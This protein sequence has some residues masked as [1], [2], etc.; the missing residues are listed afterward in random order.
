MEKP[1]TGHCESH[2]LQD[3]NAIT[4]G[5]I[6][7]VEGDQKLAYQKLHFVA[8]HS[9][10]DDVI[11]FA[12]ALKKMATEPSAAKHASSLTDLAELMSREATQSAADIEAKEAQRTTTTRRKNDP[13]S[14]EVLA[15]DTQAKGKSLPPPAPSASPA[16]AQIEGRT[17]VPATDEGNRACVLSGIMSPLAESS[18][19]YCVRAAK[20]PIVVT[21]L[22]SSSACPAELFAIAVVPGDLSSP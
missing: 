16:M 5:V 18:R 7:Y 9:D 12:G 11:A 14:V 22:H 6:T 20:G 8:S 3:C 2:G 1:V 13:P 21:D 17:I 10:P 19:G 15:S 4:D